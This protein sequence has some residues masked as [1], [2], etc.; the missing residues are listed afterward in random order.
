MNFYELSSSEGFHDLEFF[1]LRDGDRFRV[2]DT[3]SS[4]GN[5]ESVTSTQSGEH[6]AEASG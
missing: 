3:R 2:V 1:Q 6:S 5:K 4:N